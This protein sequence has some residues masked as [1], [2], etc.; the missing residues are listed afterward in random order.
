MK[1]NKL[2]L[3]RTN[4][5]FMAPILLPLILEKDA[6]PEQIQAGLTK[7]FDDVQGELK[8]LQDSGEST[9][10]QMEKAIKAIKEQGTALD[11]FIESQTKAVIKDFNHQF[12]D[13]LDE[14]KDELEKIAKNKSGVIEFV[15]K[16]VGDVTTSSGTDQ[17]TPPVSVSTSLSNINYRSDNSLIALCNSFNTNSPAFGYTEVIPKDG[18][19]AFVAEGGSKPE[20][21]WKW[22]NRYA[23]PLKIAAH[24]IMTDEAI[25]DVPRILS[26]AK[27]F[28]KKRHDLFKADG[29]YFGDGIA[30][31]A[32][33]AT[34]YARTFVAGAMAI[35][36]TDP[37]FMD[38]VNAIITDIYETHNYT[39]EM[40]YSPNI[41]LV[42][43][44]DFFLNLVAAKD[45]NGRP[46]Y[47]QASLFN[48][49]TLGGVS[50][51][52]W[53]KIPVGKI[54]VADMGKYNITNYVP[55]SVRL[56]WIND[57]FITNKFTIVG[58]SRFHAFVR[59]LDEQAFVYDTYATV[60]AAITKP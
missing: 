20:I 56:G 41:V 33:G 16:A 13:F 5:K 37:V 35:K 39:D 18:A 10:G 36:V 29:L 42:N 32:K 52:P 27:D 24:E 30:P 55:Y 15:P 8:K 11:D 38:V 60:L 4:S 19:Y 45:V 31:N 50:I 23:E 49:V 59:N 22:E 7:A 53:T 48:S 3:K 46:L 6:T 21:D 9:D 28:L 14:N 51:R 34:V 17:D 54:F 57:Q 2:R 44:V 1:K 43:P 58:E 26:V 25:K 40:S 47:P 12:S